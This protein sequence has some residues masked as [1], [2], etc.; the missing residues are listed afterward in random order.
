[1]DLLLN[2][3]RQLANSLFDANSRLF[4]GYL[5]GAIVCAA[6]V[7]MAQ[8]DKRGLIALSQFLFPRKLWWH[9]SARLDYQL[10]VVNRLIRAL[11]W[12]PIVLT[13]VPIALGASDLLEATF[14]HIQPITT[15]PTLVL[16]SFTLILFVFDD[17]TRFLLHYLMHKVPFLWHYHKVH[18]SAQVLTPMTIYR[19]HPLE[20]FLY[21]SRM[22]I[23]Q[24]LAVGLSYFLF[25]PALSMIDIFGANLFVFIFNVFGSNLRHSHVKWHWGNRIEKWFISPVQHQIHHSAHKQHFDKNFGT[26]LAIWDRLFGTLVVSKKGQKLTFGLGKG[27][28]PHRNLTDAYLRPITD[29]WTSAKKFSPPNAPGSKQSASSAQ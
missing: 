26:T 7:F 6:L 24:G 20:S 9:R 23:A 14:G 25:G 19:S 2:E 1:M 21:A 10:F 22:A 11:L 18:H 16:A 8:S 4:I 17:F 27:Q 5:I 29:H 15:H 28:Q 12:A 3:L 13:M